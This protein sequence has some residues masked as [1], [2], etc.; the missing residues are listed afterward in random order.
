M[1]FTVAAALLGLVAGAALAVS[2]GLLYSGAPL[3]GALRSPFSRAGLL[4]P[5]TGAIYAI[6]WHVA[7]HVA[8]SGLDFAFMAFFSA[9]LLVFVATDIEEHLLPNRLMYPS[10]LIALA[11]VQ[12]WPGHS[13]LW[14][15]AGGGAGFGIMFILYLLLPGFGFGDVKLAALIGLILGWPAVLFGLFLG[16]FLGGLGAL[17][18]LVSRRAGLHTAIAY[19]PYLAAGAIIEMLI[20][21]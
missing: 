14:T 3:T 17:F 15:V 13:F 11:L 19:G 6:E 10:L 7:H 20:G 16:V 1:L 2:F 18:L 4:I 21:H 9:I 5:A 12:L 8:H